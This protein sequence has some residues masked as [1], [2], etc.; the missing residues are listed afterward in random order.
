VT[1]AGDTVIAA[2]ALGLASGL[3]HAEAATIANRAGGLVVM[4]KSTA[5]V[6]A[7]ELLASL[8]L[9]T[10]AGSPTNSK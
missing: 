10:A 5:S 4:K 8:P 1:G 7:V 3:S 9:E 6:S 2:Y